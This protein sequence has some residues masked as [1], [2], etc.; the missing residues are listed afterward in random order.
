[1]NR[2]IYTYI[3]KN[4]VVITLRNL[5]SSNYERWKECCPSEAANCSFFL[6]K[7]MLE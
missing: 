3:F 5:F 6:I 2:F 4:I 7:S 1:M